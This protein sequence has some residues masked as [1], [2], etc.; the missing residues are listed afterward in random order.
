MFLQLLPY[1]NVLRVLDGLQTTIPFSQFLSTYLSRGPCFL[2]RLLTRL[3]QDFYRISNCFLSFYNKYLREK[4]LILFYRTHPKPFLAF[5]YCKVR[6]QMEGPYVR[7]LFHW[8]KFHLFKQLHTIWCGLNEWGQGDFFHCFKNLHDWSKFACLA[9][10]YQSIVKLQ[11]KYQ[12][13]RKGHC[14]ENHQF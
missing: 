3:F 9:E 7:C 8:S 13:F 11:Q 5:M 10:C 6:W 14:K 1:L 12:L 4:K 2:M